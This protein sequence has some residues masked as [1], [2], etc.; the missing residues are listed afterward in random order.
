MTIGVIVLNWNGHRD[1]V[2]CL[3]SLART[4]PRP[5]AV[6]VVDNASSDDSLARIEAWAK[7]RGVSYRM[8]QVQGEN[9][10]DPGDHLPWLTVLACDVNRGFAGGN[11][12][13]LRYLRRC[14]TIDHF[15]LLNNDATIAPDYFGHMAHTLDEIPDAGLVTGT[16]YEATHPDRV[17][18]AGGRFLP[19][20][21]LVAHNLEI[22]AANGPVETEFVSGCAML[23]SRKVLD[24][25]GLLEECYFPVYLED[26]EYSYRVG[27]AGLP[28]IYAPA[29]VAYHKV[30][31][32]VDRRF[33]S[34]FL[35]FCLNRHRLFFV[36]RN[37]RGTR[38]LAAFL[39][40][41]I[42]KP[43]RALVETLSGRPRLGWA[44]LRGTLAG[45]FSP[46]YPPRV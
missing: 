46:Y 28:V 42:T 5:K 27:Q 45:F 12:V 9:A 8:V 21:A 18:Y 41:A 37:L 25:V 30:G 16:I 3:E 31:S 23:I 22:P 38:K 24:T 33:T 14:P 10:P 19:S 13:A 43:G 35:T 2:E 17:W 20:R 15:M 4:D 7:D 36:R 40:M 39:Y 11:N 6:N 1:T 32:A 34:A 44:T 26:A 29:A